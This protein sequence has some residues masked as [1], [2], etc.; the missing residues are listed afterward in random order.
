[1]RF[2]NRSAV[3]SMLAPAFLAMSGCI[4]PNVPQELKEAK[5]AVT[6]VAVTPTT[7]SDVVGASAEPPAVLALDADGDPVADVFVDFT[8][9]TGDVWFVLASDHMRG[10]RVRSNESGIATFRGLRLGYRPGVHTISAS[11]GSATPVTFTITTRTSDVHA[12]L[13]VAGDEEIAAPGT[14]VEFPPA[15]R[16]QDLY[17]NPIAGVPVSFTVVRGGGTLTGATTISD[18]SGLASPSAW[19]LGEI[20][21]QLVVATYPGY[22]QQLEFNATAIE[23]MD[24]SCPAWE[25]LDSRASW[26]EDFTR[27]SCKTSSGRSYNVYRL[28]IEKPGLYRFDASTPIVDLHLE[29]FDSMGLPIA[30]TPRVRSSASIHAYLA[31]G[32]YTV[33]ITSASPGHTSDS[34]NLSLSTATAVPECVIAAVTSGVSIKTTAVGCHGSSFGSV[35][36]EYQIFLKSGMPVTV[37]LDYDDPYLEPYL[38]IENA[39]GTTFTTA[40]PLVYGKKSLSLNHVATK[41]GFYRLVVGDVPA[42]LSYGLSM[43]RSL[44]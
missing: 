26:T 38:S 8:L 44:P 43:D 18:S 28:S 14:A 29:L 36:D 1:M 41:D 39:A 3:V 11:S 30:R 37:Y 15:V 21:R 32:S 16:V 40:Y 20:G 9:V 31:K 17:G 24:P 10:V 23:Q 27:S 7:S 4:E 22:G 34:Y 42:G 25:V 19:T 33:A 6:L 5:P 35:L 13:K 2:T 12:P